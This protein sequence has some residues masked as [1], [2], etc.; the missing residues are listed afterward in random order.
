MNFVSLQRYLHFE[1]FLDD[2]LYD[3]NLEV[4]P[5]FHSAN[6]ITWEY[7]SSLHKSGGQKGKMKK[8]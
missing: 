6:E 2:F 5:E 7:Q 8:I 1:I 3:Y 4:T